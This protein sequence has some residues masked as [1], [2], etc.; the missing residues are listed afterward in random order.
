MNCLAQKTIYINETNK[1]ISS[2]EFQKKWRDENYNLYRW[3]YKQKD[4]GKV[5]KLYRNENNYFKV[6]YDS[7]CIEVK[8][9]TNKE[10]PKE[11]IFI[12]EYVFFNDLCTDIKKPNEWNKYRLTQKKDFFS[13]VNS[14]VK[15]FNSNIY[16]I[17]VFDKNLIIDNYISSINNFYI[18]KNYFFKSNFLQKPA[19][20]GSFILIKPD[21]HVFVKNG[22]SR[23]DF[24][25]KYLEPENWNKIFMQKK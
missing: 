10:I 11:A 18:D 14:N 4:S 8:K 17:V 19:F 23:A 5:A 13:D 22:E 24:L 15:S 9:I 7:I 20:C 16:Y 1:E 6:N 21:G 2:D 3:D 12:I 25:L